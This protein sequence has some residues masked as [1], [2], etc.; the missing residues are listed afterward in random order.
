MEIKLI[1][2]FA[3]LI[4]VSGCLAIPS[5]RLGSGINIEFISPKIN[6]VSE[7]ED[8]R[9]VLKLINFNDFDVDGRFCIRD[10]V[11]DVEHGGI[12]GGEE[13]E[14]YCSYPHLNAYDEEIKKYD[15]VTEDFGSFTYTNLIEDFNIYA[16]MSYPINL[17]ILVDNFCIQNPSFDV[18]GGNIEKKKEICNDEEIISS[19]ALK[20]NSAPLTVT[21][22][23]KILRPLAGDDVKIELEITLDKIEGVLVD[24]DGFEV[25]EPYFDFNVFY[26]DKS[27]L[28]K[29][30]DTNVNVKQGAVGDKLKL[31]KKTKEILTCSAL[32]PLEGSEPE[33][34]SLDINLNYYFKQMQTKRIEVKRTLPSWEEG[35]E[36]GEL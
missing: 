20:G 16:E 4:F 10:D 6:Y 36:G 17:N 33:F 12:I 28:C 8:V 25:L 11:K 18:L 26:K 2:L 29:I 34:G 3:I 9:V 32:F 1:L 5:D 13:K 31:K 30:R 24:P 23:K 22:I 35:Y 7:N 27:F 15:K 19:S 14:K 21:S